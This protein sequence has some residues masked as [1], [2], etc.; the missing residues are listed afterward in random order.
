MPRRYLDAFPLSG[1]VIAESSSAS[2]ALR[3]ASPNSTLS[4]PLIVRAVKESS[5]AFAI[6]TR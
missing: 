3:L 6:P 1:R 4:L 5:R 2:G